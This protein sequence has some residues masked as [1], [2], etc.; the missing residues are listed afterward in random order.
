MA[1]RISIEWCE[2]K[3]AEISRTYRELYRPLSLT[4]VA[5]SILGRPGSVLS[6]PA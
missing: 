5:D 2:R 3:T 1:A 6:R 4:Y